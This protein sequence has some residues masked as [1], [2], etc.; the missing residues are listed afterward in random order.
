MSHLHHSFKSKFDSRGCKEMDDLATAVFLKEAKQ[1]GWTAIKASRNEDVKEHWDWKLSKDSITHK[2]DIKSLKRIDS[3]KEPDDSMIC[4]EYTNV[5]GN[6]GW[7]RGE[8]D[9]IAFLLREGYVFVLRQVL[10]DYSKIVINWNDE[11]TPSPKT[12]LLHKVY[13]RSQ[14]DRKDIVAYIT[15]KELI[16]ISTVMWRSKNDLSR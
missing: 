16:S 13:Q 14:W 5:N 1:R 4:L 12:K 3:T 15:K 10:L 8:A 6:I 9:Y 2:V 11:V 7:L